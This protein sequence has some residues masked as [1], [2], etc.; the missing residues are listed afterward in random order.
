M[1]D[2]RTILAICS[3]TALMVHPVWAN[4]WR[5]GAE[6]SG[7]N[8]WVTIAVCLTV[9]GLV[10]FCAHRREYLKRRQ[11]EAEMEQLRIRHA[12]LR[13]RQAMDSAEL[14]RAEATVRARGGFF[15]MMSHEFRTPLNAIV[16]MTGLLADSQLDEEQRE[17][18][19]NVRHAS[20]LLLC[21]IND[22]LDLAKMESGA[23]HLQSTAVDLESLAGEVLSMFEV[24]ARRR[25]LELRKTVNRPL[26]P[27]VMADPIRLRQLL[28]NLVGNAIK[29]TR[30]GHVQVELSTEADQEGRPIVRVA[31]EDTGEGIDPALRDRL[32]QPFEQGKLKMAGGRPVGTGLGLAICR[33]ICEAMGGSIAVQSARGRGTR[34]SFWLPLEPAEPGMEEEQSP[35]ETVEVRLPKTGAI[36][37]SHGRTIQST[38]NRGTH[39]DAS[40]R[41]NGHAGVNGGSR[42]SFSHGLA[43]PVD[44]AVNPEPA[45][46]M[47]GV[48]PVPSGLRVVLAEDSDVNQRVMGMI[49]K[50]MGVACTFA[51]NGREAVELSREG[52]F[53]GIL[54]DLQMP[55]MD[56]LE[57]SRQITAR[58]EHPPIIALT[59]SVA[60]EERERCFQA[61]MV[62]FLLKPVRAKELAVALRE[63][64]GAM[65]AR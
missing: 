11:V 23:F 5:D 41:L 47:S 45:P 6:V 21:L 8:I 42:E 31:V 37:P 1:N 27:R 57:A 26:P 34:F 39:G 52:E 49:L 24:E 2:P 44:T 59:G 17:M 55:E 14:S 48:P 10:F 38:S 22:H 40:S 13:R 18:V 46:S 15:A 3:V 12:E 54:M 65:V 63:M 62:G 30:E 20:E 36:F 32:F 19:E 33:K 35:A 51:R 61:G 43:K 64:A 25:G 60:P 58:A 53:D 7:G 29:F 16:G 9:M 4:E 50:K 56:G 28:I